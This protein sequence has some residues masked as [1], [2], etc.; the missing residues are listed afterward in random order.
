MIC[1]MQAETRETREKKNGRHTYIF[2]FGTLVYP[3]TSAYM[4]WENEIDLT[5]LL[6][7]ECMYVKKKVQND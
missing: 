7:Y 1:P 6:F 3:S 4:V 5:F 2:N